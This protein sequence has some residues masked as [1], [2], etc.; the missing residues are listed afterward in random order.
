MPGAQA[1]LG[2]KWTGTPAE[3]AAIAKDLGFCAAWGKRHHRPICL[4]EFGAI[5]Q[6]DLASRARWI[7]FVRETAEREGMS[8]ALWGFTRSQF[9]VFDEKTGRWIQPLVDALVPPGSRR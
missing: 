2:T 1:W 8:F 5:E 9:D 3:K 7:A 4:S 6:A